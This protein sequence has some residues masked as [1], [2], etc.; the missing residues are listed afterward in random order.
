VTSYCGE[1]SLVGIA[2]HPDV[3]VADLGIGSR[4]NEHHVVVRQTVADQ[5][6]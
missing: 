1:P 4:V 5:R 6:R 2:Q 3:V